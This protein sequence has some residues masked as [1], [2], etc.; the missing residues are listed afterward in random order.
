ME[1]VESQW[2]V[3]PHRQTY[4]PALIDALRRNEKHHKSWISSHTGWIVR[5]TKARIL[6]NSRINAR[7]NTH[8]GWKRDMK[9]TLFDGQELPDVI[10][11]D[12]A[13]EI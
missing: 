11:G 10:Y 2:L 12:N 5:T 13:L 3:P 9:L 4:D 1:N 7:D 6:T 8:I